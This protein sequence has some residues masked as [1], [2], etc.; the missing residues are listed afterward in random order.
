MSGS[1]LSP[2]GR[3]IAYVAFSDGPV[4][5]GVVRTWPGKRLLLRTRS[6]E[7]PA[8]DNPGGNQVRWPSADTVEIY[9]EAGCCTDVTWYR[10]RASLAPPRILSADTVRTL[11]P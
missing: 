7:V 8:T 4:G 6:V 3:H 2:D 11:P 9:V 10:V 5:Y 1:A